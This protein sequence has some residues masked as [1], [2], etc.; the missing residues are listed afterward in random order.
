MS[1][2][3]AGSTAP[4]NEDILDAMNE[5]FEN[6]N[7]RLDSVALNIDSLL[8][9]V[10][11]I[12]A[13]IEQIHRKLD[14]VLIAT[15]FDGNIV[16]RFQARYEHLITLH[17]IA[18]SHAQ[19]PQYFDYY[20][21]YLDKLA[22]EYVDMGTRNGLL[23]PNRLEKILE[24]TAPGDVRG[25]QA[26]DHPITFEGEVQRVQLYRW[27][28]QARAS[29]WH[30]LF[31]SE[32]LK[33]R[34]EFVVRHT[35]AFVE[36]VKNY[37]KVLQKYNLTNKISFSDAKMQACKDLAPW[38]AQWQSWKWA[39]FNQPHVWL[40]K[41]NCQQPYFVD[42][43]TYW[44]P[45]PTWHDIPA[46][47]PV[48]FFFKPETRRRFDEYGD[49]GMLEDLD[50]LQCH[51]RSSQTCYR[52]HIPVCHLPPTGIRRS[53]TL[54]AMCTKPQQGPPPQEW[55][56]SWKGACAGLSRPW[57]EDFEEFDRSKRCGCE[58]RSPGRHL[59]CNTI[60]KV[61]DLQYTRTH[62]FSCQT[63]RVCKNSCF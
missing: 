1:L 32:S 13:E 53:F 47:I 5:G 48:E 4:T 46:E 39:D 11:E 58:V 31:E 28:L 19:D 54:G 43:P 35:Q 3:G 45:N 14:R 61:K 22:L 16:N 60:V 41:G 42:G 59:I 10:R 17:K 33:E 50:E 6:V 44:N 34:W 56:M 20:K 2:F 24:L 40:N 23:S 15:E 49:M 9:S 36:D 27:I 57:V 52:P 51:S 18:T 63:Q 29:L 8:V 38:V 30:V 21:K 25:I 62:C 55:R 7:R 26:G 37:D 12:Q